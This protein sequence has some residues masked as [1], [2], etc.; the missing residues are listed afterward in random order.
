MVQVDWS[1]RRLVHMGHL[2]VVR[3]VIFY[4]LVQNIAPVHEAGVV[5][6]D[7]RSG[8]GERKDLAPM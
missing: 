2:Q 6:V 5:F 4:H 8:N 7:S 3:L 1:C